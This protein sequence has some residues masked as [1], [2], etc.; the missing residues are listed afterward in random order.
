[1]KFK[2]TI[3]YWRV[4]TKTDIDKLFPGRNR[5]IQAMKD[6]YP[7]IEG[8]IPDILLL[9]WDILKST[10][11][12]DTF[13]VFLDIIK[14]VI[15]NPVTGYEVNYDG[16]YY[17]ETYCYPA[18]EQNLMYYYASFRCLPYFYKSNRKLYNR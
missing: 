14:G 16:K 7:I 5:M 15:H 8:H 18:Y 9:K 1:M 3:P 13:P 6:L 11:L 12:E 2:K 17:I 4:A 10:R